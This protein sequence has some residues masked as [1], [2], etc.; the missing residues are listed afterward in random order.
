MSEFC[1]LVWRQ[2]E[3]K[4]ERY[5]IVF[6]SRLEETGDVTFRLGWVWGVFAEP[7]CF[8]DTTPHQVSNRTVLEQLPNTE[9]GQVD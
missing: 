7:R 8:L 2:R 3:K 9:L 1:F 6:N 5:F 4:V